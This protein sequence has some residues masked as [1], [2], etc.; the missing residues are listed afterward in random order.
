MFL[1]GS[2]LSFFIIL[3]S[4]FTYKS[5]LAEKAS[6]T[7]TLNE[8]L[9]NVVVL[10]Q[11]FSK[12]KSVIDSL[13]P[14][15]QNYSDTAACEHLS[16]N[17]IWNPDF[18]ESF[19]P[20]S[21]YRKLPDNPGDLFP[22]DNGWY[23]TASDPSALFPRWAGKGLGNSGPFMIIDGALFNKHIVWSQKIKVKP[24]NW[25]CFK[26]WVCTL[27][28]PETQPET[29]RYWAQAFIKVGFNDGDYSYALAPAKPFLWKPVQSFWFSGND[30]IVDITI[31]DLNTGIRYNDFGIDHMEFFACECPVNIKE[32]NSDPIHVNTDIDKAII[33]TLFTEELKLLNLDVAAHLNFSETSTSTS[34][35]LI[36]KDLYVAC[37][38][39]SSFVHIIKRIGPQLILLL[40]S[41]I[42][43]MFIVFLIRKLLFEQR[44]VNQLKYDITNNITHELKTPVSGI[45]ASLDILKQYLQLNDKEKTEKYI[46]IAK[47]Q[48]LKLNDLINK[49]LELDMLSNEDFK[50]VIKPIDLAE[51][52]NN[53]LA[54][55]KYRFLNGPQIQFYK[56]GN[57]FVV[58]GDVFHIKN[59]INTILDNAIKYCGERPII[60]ITITEHEKFVDLSISDNGIGIPAEFQK[61][62]FD[63]YFRVPTKDVHTQRGYGLG[64]YYVKTIMD[65]LK[66]E[67]RLESK[68][69]TGTT[70]N[71]I[72][73]K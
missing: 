73:R 72:F 46:E 31:T 32:L 12:N 26:T 11:T 64:L 43:S 4:I 29:N 37:I 36:H 41:V 39:D 9:H 67:I 5:F 49:A 40:L 3:L 44:K 30:S 6:L 33:E 2:L 21:E 16:A 58:D 63:K 18:N 23:S 59:I 54:Q 71:L 17:L 1:L 24:N 52:I 7:N 14:G 35:F 61:A 45:V 20:Y 8:S 60:I 25:Y 22:N 55:D 34:S 15:A 28:V 19:V 38:I 65:L 57:L 10:Y 68:E 62:V 51:V 70:I 50:L 48:T 69:K 47:N 27:S 56:R 66:G 13:L 53:V 42:S